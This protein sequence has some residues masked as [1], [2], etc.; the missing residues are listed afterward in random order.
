MEDSKGWTSEGKPSVKPLMVILKPQGP[1]FEGLVENEFFCMRL[2]DDGAVRLAPLYDLVCTQA[3]PQLAAESA[4]KIGDE[5]KSDRI[6]G[7]NW[8][9]FFNDAGVGPALARKRLNAL[10]VS[11]SKIVREVDESSPGWKLVFRAVQANCGRVLS[12]G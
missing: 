6:V 11:V 12:L 1:Y 10:A 9:N 4:M 8:L 3:Y 7:K 5:R 2:Y